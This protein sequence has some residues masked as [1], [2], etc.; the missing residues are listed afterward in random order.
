VLCRLAPGRLFSER[1]GLLLPC[2]IHQRSVCINWGSWPGR[3]R[4]SSAV[5]SVV[6]LKRIQHP[7][8]FLDFCNIHLE[9]IF[10]RVRKIS[11]SDYSFVISVCFSVRTEQLCSYWTSLHVIWCLG[12][13]RKSF[14][15]IHVLLKSDK[16][17][18]HF[19]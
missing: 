16:N 9:W 18:R 6:A 7:V 17:I 5:H 3:G 15:N 2:S 13:F 11:K 19:A 8:F 1:L 12:I 4:I 10:R 14:E